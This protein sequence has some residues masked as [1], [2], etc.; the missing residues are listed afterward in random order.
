MATVEDY[1]STLSED[2]K[3]A[4]ERLRDTIRKNLP[5]G[6]EETINYNMPSWVVP[7]TI[8][9]EGYHVNP[10]LPLPFLGIASQRRHIG[11][12]HMGI[13]ASPTLLEWF[14]QEYANHCKTKLDMDK[15]CIRF[16]NMAKIPYELIGE[17]C[18]KMSVQEWIDLYQK[19][20]L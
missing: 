10:E 17:L 20:R 7:H 15:S 12:Y 16:K 2:R 3:E 1:F 4:M 8:F 5:N 14:T 11:V 19:Q 13:Y 18:S 9:P 6:F